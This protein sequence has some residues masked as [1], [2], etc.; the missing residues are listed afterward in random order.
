[1]EKVMIPE[2]TASKAKCPVFMSPEFHSPQN[3]NKDKIGLVLIQGAG[4][5]RAGL[6]SRSVSVNDSLE[7]GSMF[8]QIEWAVFEKQHPVLVMNPNYNNDPLKGLP[9]P[10]SETMVSHALH[11]WKTYVVRS[12]FKKILVIA[13]SKGGSCLE[14]IM[15]ENATTFYKQ[16][17]QIAITD[18]A[19]SPTLASETHKKFLKANA[20]H[21]RASMKQLGSQVVPKGGKLKPVCPLLSAGHPK[22]E[23]TTGTSWPMI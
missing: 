19:F 16:V 20:I 5:V 22:H 15:K 10:Q 1:M 2:K 12:G 17:K 9:I 13:H 6:W 11:V 7:L 23:Y 4:A 18:S 3:T 8:P 14:A 21:Y